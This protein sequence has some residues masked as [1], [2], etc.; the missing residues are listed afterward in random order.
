MKLFVPCIAHEGLVMARFAFTAQH[1]NG[2]TVSGSRRVRCISELR[3]WLNDR[4]LL[5]ISIS[6]KPRRWQIEITPSKTKRKVLIHF[7]RQLSVFVRSGIPLSSALEILYDETAD[8]ALRRAVAAIIKDISLGETLSYGAAQHPQVFPHYYV[9]LI[10]SAEQ[11]GRLDESLDSLATYLQRDV[12]TRSSITSALAYPSIVVLLSLVTVAVLTGYVLPQFKPLFAELDAQLPT[13]TRLLL[14]F[15]AAF[16]NYIALVI[17]LVLVAA[18][19]CLWMMR[20]RRGRTYFDRAILRVPIVR[21]VVH[22]II[23]ERFCRVLATMVRSGIAIPEGMTIGAAA[24]NNSEIRR[25]LEKARL[26]VERGQGFTGPLTT[27][28]LFPTAAMQMFRV[29]EE[30]G[31]LEDQL[32]AA[33][34]YFDTELTQRIRKFTTLFEPAMIIGVGLTVGF[35]AVALVSAM[36]GVLDG[37]KEPLSAS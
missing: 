5:P 15:S 25:R 9:G 11:T 2:S 19:G 36:Y 3:R 23:L 31:T 14:G 30:T 29:G 10:R 21:N 24:T 28:N 16:T 37:V 35:V 33:S 32:T 17:F 22:F 6:E 34:E 13:P 26:E 1:K 8:T 4:D 27:T 18:G 12:D 7:T 20:S